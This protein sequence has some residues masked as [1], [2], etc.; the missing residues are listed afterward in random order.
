MIFLMCSNL[1]LNSLL[2]ILI[3]T[4]LIITIFFI[5]KSIKKLVKLISG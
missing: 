5:R 2:T 4:C 3:Y 1:K